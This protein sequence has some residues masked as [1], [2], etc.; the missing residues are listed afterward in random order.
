M[1]TCARCSLK[2]SWTDELILSSN[3]YVFAVMIE[4]MEQIEYKIITYS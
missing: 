3:T 4:T 2:N 1:F